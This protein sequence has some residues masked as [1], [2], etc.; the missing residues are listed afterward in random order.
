MEKKIDFKHFKAFTDISQERTTEVDVHKDI[1]DAIYKNVNGI[2]AHDLALRIYR[3]EGPV[4]L[5]EE[6]QKILR[7]FLKNTT[8]IFMDSFEHNLTD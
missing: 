7:D 3:S 1:A 2:A 8:P 6:D 4:E 5:S